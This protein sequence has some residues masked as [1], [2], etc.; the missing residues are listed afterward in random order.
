LTGFRGV[1]VSNG[2]EG[3]DV[4]VWNNGDASDRNEGGPGDDTAVL[5]GGAADEHFVVTG[6]G[7]RVTA[8]RDTQVPFFLDIGTS[9]L[10]ELNALGGRD[11]VDVG[12]GVGRVLATDLAG[13]DGN[14]TFR[15]RNDSVQRIDGGTGADFAQVDARDILTNV[16]VTDKPGVT[17]PAGPPKPDTVGPKV[18]VASKTLRVK[19]GRAS[20]TISCPAGESSCSGRARI[21]RGKKVVGSTS[22]TLAGGER[23]TFKIALT[24]KTRI[25]LSKQNDDRLPVTV[26]VSVKDAAGNTGKASR[27]VNLQG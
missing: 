24:R 26:T 17:P 23:Q 15:T 2:D 4:M 10:L 25:A 6:N 8:T 9:E 11:S 5:N 14:D 3:D 27:R 7:A 19:G 1:D 22:V 12:D 13:G 20:L 16:E 21:V 18:A